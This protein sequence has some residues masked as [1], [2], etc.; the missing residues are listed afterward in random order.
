MGVARERFR[1]RDVGWFEQWKALFSFL[2]SNQSLIMI[3]IL[4][5]VG[6]L[7]RGAPLG[8]CPGAPSVTALY[9]LS[10]KK[11]IWI[12]PW[13]YNFIKLCDLGIILASVLC[14]ACIIFGIVIIGSAMGTAAKCIFGFVDGKTPDLSVSYLTRAEETSC[15]LVT[16]TTKHVRTA[17]TITNSGLDFLPRLV[18]AFWVT[19]GFSDDFFSESWRNR[20][21]KKQKIHAGNKYC[22]I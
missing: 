16:M 5:K 11:K 9:Y 13:R 18:V 19:D 22:N 4:L 17:T 2:L 1:E 10:P 15:L 3:F 20:K 7:C 12:H 8:Q 6:G 14:R 21:W